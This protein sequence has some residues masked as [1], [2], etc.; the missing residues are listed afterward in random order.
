MSATVGRRVLRLETTA[1][2]RGP[3]GLTVDEK[4]GILSECDMITY[5]AGRVIVVSADAPGEVARWVQSH[6]PPGYDV[7]Y[8][9]AR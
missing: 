8:G 2:R 7:A 6:A 9:Q 4:L 3:A 1:R 5:H